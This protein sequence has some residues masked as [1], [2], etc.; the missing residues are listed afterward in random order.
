MRG[1]KGRPVA[2]WALPLGVVFL[3]LVAGVAY[4]FARASPAPMGIALAF[5]WAVWATR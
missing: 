1:R 2:V 4:S 3:G 5:A